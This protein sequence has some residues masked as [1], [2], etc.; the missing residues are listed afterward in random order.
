MSNIMNEWFETHS[1]EYGKFELVENKRSTHPDLHAFLLLEELSG[2]NN[3]RNVLASAEHDEV[4]LSFDP[5]VIAE[6]VTEAQ[7]IELI[8][9]GVSYCDS[10][11]GFSM[12]A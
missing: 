8:R 2:V 1:N 10:Y 3:N 12:F 4:W 9:G 5:S 7:V 6:T 11:D